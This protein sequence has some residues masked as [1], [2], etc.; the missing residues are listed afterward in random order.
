[1]S[2]RTD[3][4]GSYP[5]PNGPFAR[6]DRI[7]AC[8]NDGKKENSPMDRQILNPPPNFYIFPQTIIGRGEPR[9]HP[10][11]DAAFLNGQKGGEHKVR[12][13]CLL[14][15]GGFRKFVGV[16]GKILFCYTFLCI[17]KRR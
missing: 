12:P 16:D 9:V 3:Q 11:M 4:S 13:Y 7:Q 15:G 17:V 8:G 14:L 2:A 10:V 6:L 1:L 5:D